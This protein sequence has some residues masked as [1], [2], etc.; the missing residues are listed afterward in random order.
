MV[1]KYYYISLYNFEHSIKCNMHTHYPPL[2]QDT[3]QSI[4]ANW[5]NVC[6]GFK[7]NIDYP[8]N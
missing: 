2:N 1:K 6:L 8:L 4:T 5:I 3:I 7:Y